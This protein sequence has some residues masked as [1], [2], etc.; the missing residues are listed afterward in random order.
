MR[1]SVATGTD[2]GFPEREMAR[3]ERG[4]GRGRLCGPLLVWALGLAFLLGACAPAEPEKPEIPRKGISGI[5]GRAEIKQDRLT[6][7]AEDSRILVTWSHK[8]EVAS[9]TLFWADTHEEA[10]SGGTA[11]EGLTKARFEHKEL[12][13]GKT[14]YYRVQGFTKAG[15]PVG[16][17]PVVGDI[18]YQYETR[19]FPGFMAV[20]PRVHDTF[21][22][23][24]ERYLKDPAKDWMIREFNDLTSVTPFRVVMIPLES[25]EPGSL[26]REGYRTVPILAYHNISR[27]KASRMSVLAT[28]FE[29]QMAYLRQNRFQVITLRQFVDFLEFK[30]QVPEKAVVITFDDGWRSTYEIALPVLKRYGYPATLFVYTDLVGSGRKALSWAQ[31]RSIEKS[32]VIDVQCHT[33]SHRNLQMQPGEDMTGYF[34][35][36]VQEMKDSRELLRSKTGKNCTY[37]AYPYGAYNHLVTALAEEIGYRAAF[38]VRR[39]S[40]PF[41]VSNYRVLRSLVF[42]EDD[43]ET[44]AAGLMTY[45]DKVVK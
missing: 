20:T 11:I 35:A 21:A 36:L 23:L 41:F 31:V 37:L 29:R 1:F 22:S 19:R 42:G 24:A 39:G 2:A 27:I 44:F 43:L 10:E 16:T 33:K 40:N 25:Y 14:Y 38:T 12:E 13:N 3:G 34:K 26:T 17:Y 6:T 30:G 15:K 8:T 5:L 9:Y 18:P 45:D 4:S 7:W 32:G 28:E